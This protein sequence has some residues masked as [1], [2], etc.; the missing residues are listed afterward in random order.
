MGPIQSFDDFRDMLR[1]RAFV[2]FFVAFAGALLSLWVAA[3]RQH[4]YE[5]A[6]VIQVRQPQIADD[7][8]KSTVEGS[9]AR[10]L[11]LIE[12]RLMARGTLLEIIDAYG[13]FAE[14]PGLTPS[15]KVVLMRESVSIAG[16][17]A[18]REGYSDDG[19][20]SV[21]TIAVRMPSPE[22]A[23][24]VA[25][26]FSRRTI[27]LSIS[28]RIAQARETLN[29]F[30]A[31]EAALAE[32]IAALEAE[33]TAYRNANDVSMP[34]SIEFRRNEIAAINQSLLDI[35]R[36]EIEVRRAADRANATERPATA[37]RMLAAY[38][39]EL[40]TLKAQSE[41]LQQRKEELE[42]S[43]ETTPEVEQ[44]LGAYNR[45][46]AQLRG[47]LEQMTARRSDAEVGFR[48]E[49][50][51]QSERLTVLEPAPLPDYPVT[52]GRKKLAMLG[53]L[54]S[55]VLAVGVAFLLDLRHPVLRTSAHMER[56]TGL[57]PVVVIPELKSR[58]QRRR[59][60]PLLSRAGGTK[61]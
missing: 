26:E 58:R 15:E 14:I 5:S 53:S 25:R 23:Q 1:R 41:L 24:Q 11:Q 39:E 17:A 59:W 36:E 50:A 43:L 32:E 33:I 31:K 3:S 37:R 8:A 21:L 61:A 4:L 27:E 18:A 44:T 56:A 16:V 55:L 12:Q 30:T 7:L 38:E 60:W 34:G 6:E 48:L 45:R 47:E 52:G 9:S 42:A 13:L 57:A 49:T 28:S 19:T 35:A 2:I 20:V 29:F 54:A 46:M 51:R 10:R 40:E 22:L